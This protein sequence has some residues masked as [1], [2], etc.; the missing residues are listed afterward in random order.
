MKKLFLLAGIAM[1]SIFATGSFSPG[2]NIGDVVKNF[3]AKN[4]DGTVVSLK[5]FPIAEG[6]VVVFTCNTCPYA[7]AYE[8]RINALAK[9]LD[10]QKWPLIAI[11]SNDKGMSPGDSYEKMQ[12]RSKDHAYSFPYIYDENQSIVN[13]FGASKTPHFYVLDKTKKVRYIGALDDNADDANR[14]TRHYVEDAIK[15]IQAGK[16]PIPNFTRAIGCHIK[17]RTS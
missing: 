11:N 5:N 12:K 7:Q 15:A 3:E 8:E 6:Y 9:K 14:V 17:K 1:I 4:I 2:Y 13:E 16:D 10:D